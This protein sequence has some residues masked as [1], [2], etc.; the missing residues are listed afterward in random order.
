MTFLMFTS[1]RVRVLALFLFWRSDLGNSKVAASMSP[2]LSPWPGVKG[3]RI[4][5]KTSERSESGS[6]K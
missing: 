5:K 3:A 1:V 2:T 4:A 6:L